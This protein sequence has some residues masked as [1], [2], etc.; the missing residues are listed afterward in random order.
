MS[1]NGP[2][3]DDA[4]ERFQLAANTARRLVSQCL[5]HAEKVSRKMSDRI[6]AAT[7]TSAYRIDETRALAG[8]QLLA[9]KQILEH[10]EATTNALVTHLAGLKRLLD[11]DTFLP[12][13]AMVL[14]RAI[15]EVA[16]SGAWIVHPGLS[17]EERAARGYAAMF[18]A[19]EK[20]IAASGPEDAAAMRKLRDKLI[21]QLQ[22]PGTNVEIEYRR[23]EH[24][25]VQDD[26]AQVFVRNGRSRARAKVRFKYSQRV[27]D[28]IP[29]ASQLYSALSGV[30]HGEHASITTSWSTPDA[31]AR[32]IAHVVVESTEA[33]SRAV[34]D[35]V[36]VTPGPFL[37]ESDRG[38]I[39]RS[40]PEATRA[41]AMAKFA[42]AV[43]AGA[44]KPPGR[45]S[46][47]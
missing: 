3:T 2:V 25:V 46:G 37:N 44:V 7:P 22:R 15:A 11:D 17:T 39:L 13:P 18:A 20:G 26:V 27:R 16:A 34:H 32:V 21:A 35:W 47:A 31:Y 36:G 10:V 9:Y 38:N 6:A 4:D 40:M 29:R 43:Q 14:A 45:A 28:E 5:A 8:Q 1:H 42:A 12:L 23:D 41:S 19:V 24:G 33:W 30:A